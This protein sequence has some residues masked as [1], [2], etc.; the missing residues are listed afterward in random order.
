MGSTDDQ[1]SLIRPVVSIYP[2]VT[3]ST[4]TIQSNK[5]ISQIKVINYIG[6]TIQTPKADNDKTID[7]SSQ[8]NGIYFISIYTIDGNITTKRVVKN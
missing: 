2:S 8:A 1:K 5:E 6:K 3:K 4:V 7:L